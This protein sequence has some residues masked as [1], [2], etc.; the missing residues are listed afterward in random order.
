MVR[1]IGTG[2]AQ[3]RHRGIVVRR[4]NQIEL[5]CGVVQA[6]SGNGRTTRDSIPRRVAGENVSLAVVQQDAVLI[7]A[8]LYQI[9]DDAIAHIRSACRGNRVPP[10]LNRRAAAISA[11]IRECV[12]VNY[13]AIAED[14][15]KNT[16]T[17]LVEEVITNDGAVPLKCHL[18]PIADYCG[19]T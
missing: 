2:C 1:R 12:S 9:I 17:Y 11:A 4:D 10:K 8:G 5:G 7:V 6:Y 19:C 15:A 18:I 3:E 13:R 14:P 16:T